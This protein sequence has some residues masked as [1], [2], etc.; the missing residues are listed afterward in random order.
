MVR[1]NEEEPSPSLLFPL[2]PFR[3]FPHFLLT[4]PKGS[5]IPRSMSSVILKCREP[6]QR[7]IGPPLPFCRLLAM[8]ASRFFSAWGRRKWWLRSH[9]SYLQSHLLMSVSQPAHLWGLYNDRHPQQPLPS[10]PNGQWHRL[11]FTEFHIG[12]ALRTTRVP[13]WDDTYITNLCRAKRK[14]WIGHKGGWME[15]GLLRR[16]PRQGGYLANSR[17]KVLQ[18]SRPNAGS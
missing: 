14:S 9:V 16:K 12:N 8:A 1:E 15:E 4:L 6:T 17:E 13:I 11:D 18:V 5:K 3:G 10:Q 2:K 7:R